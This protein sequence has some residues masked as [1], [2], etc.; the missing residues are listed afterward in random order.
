MF[1]L[2][3]TDTI[4]A[5]ILRLALISMRDEYLKLRANYPE[6]YPIDRVK[7]LDNLLYSIDTAKKIRFEIVE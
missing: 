5:S 1:D 4:D 3:T 6:Y 2:N 7:Y